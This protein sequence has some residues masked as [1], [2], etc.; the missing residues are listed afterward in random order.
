MFQVSAPTYIFV[1]PLNQGVLNS[2][3][4]TRYECF[5]GRSAPLYGL[6]EAKTTT[7]TG[8]IFTKKT[9]EGKS[10]VEK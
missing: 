5:G 1:D 8:H 7:T 10:R 2:Y 4:K 3:I 9:L 6:K